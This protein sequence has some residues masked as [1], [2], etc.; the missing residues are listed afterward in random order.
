MKKNKAIFGLI[1][2]LGL[3][4][5]MGSLQR[6]TQA[7]VGWGISAFF[8]ADENTTSTNVVGGTAAG[9]AIAAGAVE[10]AEIG[11]VGGVIGVAAGA[12]I[13]GL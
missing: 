8:G 9:A 13:G 7:N 3:L 11:V 2:S 1:L 5:S 4:V 6:T 10:G 12:I